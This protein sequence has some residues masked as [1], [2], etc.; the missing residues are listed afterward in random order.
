MRCRDVQQNLDLLIR[1]E[2]MPPV[3]ERI[4]VHLRGCPRCREELA[5]L[6]RLADLLAAAPVPP[7]PEG[8]AGRVIERARHEALPDAAA[9]VVG[10]RVGR[11]LGRRVRI[12]ASTAAALAG[13]LLLGGFLGNQTWEGAPPAGVAQA[14]PLAES[15]LGQLAEPGGDSLARAYL[16]LTADGDS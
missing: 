11:R 14:D 13:G 5:R 10:R 12:A 8:F 1:Q 3:R 2:L 15:G 4:E 6:R 16:A 7:V 9:V